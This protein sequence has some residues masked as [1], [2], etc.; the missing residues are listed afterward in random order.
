MGHPGPSHRDNK[1]GKYYI[2]IN[3]SLVL[4]IFH[5]DCRSMCKS[6]L[7]FCIRKVSEI[8]ILDFFSTKLVNSAGGVNKDVY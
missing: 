8:D 3:P 5:I 2:T 6:G 4:S 7:H 1:H